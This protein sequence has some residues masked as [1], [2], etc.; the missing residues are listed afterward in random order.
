[1]EENVRRWIEGF[2]KGALW[3]SPLVGFCDVEDVE[4]VRRIVSPN[5][6]MPDEVLSAARSVIVYFIPFAEEVV[7]SNIGGYYSSRLWAY[8]YVKT[9][10]LIVKI[11]EYLARKLERYGYRSAV[12]PP[13]HDF[14]ETR[15]I[16][17]WSHKHIA[18]LAGLGTFGVHT[19]I[20]TEKGCCGRIGSLIT[21]AEFR[22]GE[23]LKEELCLHKR[24]RSCLQCVRRCK[25]GALNERGLDKRRCYEVL[26]ENDRY[27]SDIPSL[28]DVCGKC[29]CGVPCDMQAPQFVGL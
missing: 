13:T 22:Y 21:Q 4:I 11:N 10:E 16:S 8:A 12:L 19:L 27:H 24:G 28:T 23:P 1:M 15:L 3:R 5:H 9:N 7:R 26:L 20:I 14:D 2:V 18:Y 29:C 6:L 25:F 17:N